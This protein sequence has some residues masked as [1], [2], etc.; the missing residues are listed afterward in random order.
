MFAAVPG[1]FV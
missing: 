1:M